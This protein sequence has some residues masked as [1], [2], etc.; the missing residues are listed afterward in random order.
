MT[1][2]NIKF[3]VLF[4]DTWHDSK[5]WPPKH[6]KEEL[7]LGSNNSLTYKKPK[8]LNSESSFLFNPEK[9]TPTLGG[10]N[11]YFFADKMGIKD[12]ST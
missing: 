7:Y 12:Q 4:E 9:P 5:Q 10:A 6:K 2:E 11:F 1:D 8:A 3:Y